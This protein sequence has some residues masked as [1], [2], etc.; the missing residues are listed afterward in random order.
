MIY[1]HLKFYVS[2]IQNNKILCI[3]L[4]LGIVL[5]RWSKLIKGYKVHKASIFLY[6]FLWEN[7]QRTTIVVYWNRA[8]A[9]WPNLLC[10]LIFR[11]VL[12]CSFCTDSMIRGSIKGPA[13]YFVN[14][15][16][17]W[18][19]LLLMYGIIRHNEKKKKV[20]CDNRCCMKNGNYYNQFCSWEMITFMYFIVLV[21]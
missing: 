15:H 21:N 12:L 6:Q 9:K 11:Y 10:L 13:F 20:I 18:K 4:I 8:S 3:F 19:Y 16:V 14:E 17:R 1:R 5:W 2:V 7:I